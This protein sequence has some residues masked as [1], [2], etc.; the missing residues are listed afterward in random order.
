MYLPVT[1]KLS[2]LRI[3]LL[4]TLYSQNGTVKIFFVI[5]MFPVLEI[6]VYTL[7]YS[8]LINNIH[9]YITSARLI[10]GEVIRENRESNAVVTANLVHLVHTHSVL[11]LLRDLS[12]VFPYCVFEGIN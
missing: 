9:T 3:E 11:M 5:N 4:Y 7:L 6:E 10:L 8:F 12:L 2:T 1:L